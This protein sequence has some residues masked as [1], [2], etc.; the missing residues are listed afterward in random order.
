MILL[1]IRSGGRSVDVINYR[2]I[3]ISNITRVIS[4]IHCGQISDSIIY[5]NI[6]SCNEIWRT[7][8]IT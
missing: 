8:N 3:T 6:I 7:C 2:L 1:D 5:C 4:Y